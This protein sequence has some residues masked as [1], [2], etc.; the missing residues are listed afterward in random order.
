MNNIKLICFDLDDT[1][2]PCRPTIHKAEAVYYQWLQDN[3]P[4]ITDAYSPDQ[5]REKR[6]Q[7][8][9]RIPELAHDMSK[10]R[11]HSL[12]EL[13]DE[14]GDGR[15]WINEAF[16]AFYQARQQVSFYDDVTPVL[17]K[18]KSH[19]QLATATNGNA[20]ISVTELASYFDFSVSA[21]E[22]GLLKPDPA[23]FE[24]LQQKSQL[25]AEAIL[26]VGD[27][28]LDDIEGARR[29]GITNIWLDRNQQGWSHHHPEP[30]YIVTDLYQIL[31][32]LGLD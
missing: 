12:Y 5:L 19:Y 28:A 31:D 16:D 21:S 22:A 8:R 1:L 20:D 13:A 7:L 18:L 11:I 29:A 14:F 32:L 10:L 6:K 26:H 3:K 2:W 25:T 24:L 27:H 23:M 9:E 17:T 30:D 4:V 15:D